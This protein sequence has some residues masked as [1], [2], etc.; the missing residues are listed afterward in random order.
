MTGSLLNMLM[1]SNAV[2]AID[3]HEGDLVAEAPPEALIL[4]AIEP[5]ALR[6][7]RR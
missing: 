7:R 2:G 3:F 1:K 6:A 4:D 5:N